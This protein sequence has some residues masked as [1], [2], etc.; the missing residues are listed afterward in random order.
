MN[1]VMVCDFFDPDLEYQENSLVKYYKS[2][3]HSVTVVTSTFDDVFDYYNDK[4]DASKPGETYWSDGAKIVKCKYKYNILNKYRPFRSIYPILE[5]EKP[6]LIFFHDII[7][8]IGEGV[9]YVKRHQ[10]CVMIMDYHADFSNSGANWL[11][12][13]VL[14]RLLRGCVLR[15]ARPHLQKI[16]PIVPE[17]QRFLEVIYGV[18]RDEMEILPLGVDLELATEVRNSGEGSK[19]R[20]ALDI[21]LDAFV[22][23]TGGKLHPLKKTERLVE[24]LEDPRCRGAHLLVVG[25]AGEKEA[26]YKRL[27][28][29]RCSRT[30]NV[31]FCGWQAKRD[32]YV[33]MA[34]SDVAIF[35]ASQSVLWQQSIGMGL[36]LI[37]SERS[38]AARGVQSVQYLNRHENVRVLDHEV[39]LAPQIA[40]HVEELRAHPERRKKMSEGALRVARDLLDWNKVVDQTL[41]FNC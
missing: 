5:A 18:E 20:A 37:V 23:F 16:F 14:H 25:D 7:P 33:H 27:I 8:N 35:P 2:R 32:V 17:G 9:R 22:I 39:P 40:A 26:E 36:P 11:S 34:A 3:G 28:L 19:L 29:E 24:A 21:P 31:H 1:I 15:S 12:I 13:N 30:A 38:D 10:N 6:D 41:R 4:H